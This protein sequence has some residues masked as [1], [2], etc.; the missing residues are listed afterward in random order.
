MTPPDETGN[1]CG[2]SIDIVVQPN[3]TMGPALLYS[4]PASIGM[5]GSYFQL[6]LSERADVGLAQPVGSWYLV[7]ANGR[8]G[9]V[10][11][12]DQPD[13]ITGL[14]DGKNGIQ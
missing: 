10:T 6:W 8:N 4:T 12:L 14:A 9:N 5:G 1:N 3:G 13:L 7:T 11:T 2:P